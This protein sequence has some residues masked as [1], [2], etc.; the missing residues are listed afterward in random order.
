MDPIRRIQYYKVLKS[1]GHTELSENS[2]TGE[3]HMVFDFVPE[4]IPA[5][6]GI[7]PNNLR[8]ITPFITDLV[9]PEMGQR[10]RVEWSLDMGHTR[11]ELTFGQEHADL[12]RDAWPSIVSAIENLRSQ[13]IRQ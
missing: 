6:F 8:R 10:G 11:L 3:V 7:E 1:I 4:R 12:A 9:V 5:E 2:A 13:H